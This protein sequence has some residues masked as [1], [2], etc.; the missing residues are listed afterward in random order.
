MKYLQIAEL[1]KRRVEQGDYSGR[2]LPG[3]QSLAKEIGC[4]YL[5]AR[6][7]IQ[8]LVEDGTLIRRGNG[9]LMGKKRGAKGKA[10]K[11]VVLIRA[12]WTYSH[13]DRCIWET[14]MKN[15]CLFKIVL[16]NHPD[17]PEITEALD[18]DYDIVFIYPPHDASPILLKRLAAEKDRVVTV[19]R[20]CTDLGIRCLDGIPSNRLRDLLQYLLKLGH[21]GVDFFNTEPDN[22]RCHEHMRIWESMKKEFGFSGRALNFP[23]KP[24]DHSGHAAKEAMDAIL[25]GGEELSTAL[26]CNS[27]GAAAG[28]MRSLKNHGIE[29]PRD[30]SVCCFG[31]HLNTSLS[32]PSLTTFTDFEPT[33]EIRE[34][35][36]A[37][38]GKGG[39]PAKLKYYS[40]VL[41]LLPG[42]STSKPR[43][44]R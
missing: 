4:S 22:P 12:A 42:E 14:A 17:D 38:L 29:I 18:A 20:D 35:Y 23:C 40:K 11:K 30:I 9:R 28:A 33:E 7:S 15:G 6:H 19:H 13:W 16:Y 26:F 39:D 21:K 25:D 44:K 1:L 27:S 8:K 32:I 2:V 37:L 41:T 10:L 43:R 3:A 31:D 5:T 36:D 34:I 24:F